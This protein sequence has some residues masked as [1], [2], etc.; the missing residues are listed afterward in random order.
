MVAFALLAALS[1]GAAT[2]RTALEAAGGGSAVTTGAGASGRSGAEAAV[3]SLPTAARV[4]Q[5]KP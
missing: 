2:S 3:A 5:G 1:L 4:S